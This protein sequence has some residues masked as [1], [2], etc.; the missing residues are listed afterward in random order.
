MLDF[1]R[2]TRRVFKTDFPRALKRQIIWTYIRLFLASH[3]RGVDE[4][5]SR[6]IGLVGFKF[7]YLDFEALRYAFDEIFINLDYSFKAEV[8]KPRIIDCG[9]NIGLSIAF[10]KK[11]F[12]QAEI[13]AFEPNKQAFAVL[14]ENIRNNGW[15][16]VQL[17]Q[18]ALSGSS[19]IMDFY[20]DPDHS[21]SLKMS[22]VRERM[23]GIAEPVEAVLLSDFIDEEVDFLKLDVEGAEE[24][25]LRDLSQTGKLRR[26]R[27]MVVEY[28]H[29]IQKGTDALS[30]LLSLLE[31]NDF[32]YSIDA[33]LGR[34]LSA[35][36]GVFQDIL[37]YAYRKGNNV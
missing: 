16:K 22:L 36:R 3:A 31:N 35:K 37:I 34:P 6:R 27:E 17:H 33:Q 25:V 8:E 29:H 24:S 2:I 28:H 30:T 11:L 9:S 18:N 26:I 12:P 10:F 5:D 14:E 19:G 20:S 32:G 23:P 15:Q 7:S 4:P 13:T 21:G 1:L